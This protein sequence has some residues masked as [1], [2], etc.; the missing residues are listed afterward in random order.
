VQYDTLPVRRVRLAA[1]NTLL[2]EDDLLWLLPLLSVPAADENA[3]SR[4][5]AGLHF[6]F[7]CEAGQNLGKSGKWTVANHLRSR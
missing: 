4:G 7:A 6:R 5:V 3:D 2:T 1:L